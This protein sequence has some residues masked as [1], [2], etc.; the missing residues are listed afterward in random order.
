MSSS[1][2][3]PSLSNYSLFLPAEGRMR[4]GL[5]EHKGGWVFRGL[6]RRR[7]ECIL[8]E[9]GGDRVWGEGE[10]HISKISD[11]HNAHTAHVQRCATC[12]S[13]HSPVKLTWRSPQSLEW[14][15]WLAELHHVPDHSLYQATLEEKAEHFW[16]PMQYRLMVA[17]YD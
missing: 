5:E 13:A 16:N 8:L 7:G 6:A 9:W 17:L 15:R 1:L 4:E 3:V 12:S 14:G 2:I 10:W 11:A